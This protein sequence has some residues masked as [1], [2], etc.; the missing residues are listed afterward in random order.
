MALS[1]AADWRNS[2]GAARMSPSCASPDDVPPCSARAPC[3]S[4][5][6]WSAPCHR[7][8][9]LPRRRRPHPR[10]RPRRRRHRHR[11]RHPRRRRRRPRRPTPTPTPQAVCPYNGR[12]STIQRPG[13]TR[14]AC[15]VQVENHPSA[16]APGLNSADMVVEAPVEGDTTRFSA[17]FLCG[18]VAGSIG[19]VRTTATTTSTTGSRC[20]VMTFNFGGAG[21]CSTSCRQRHALRERH[22]RPVA[23]LRA[24]QRAGCAAQRVLRPRRRRAS[25]RGARGLAS[26]SRA[27]DRARRSCSPPTPT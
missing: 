13:G 10:R 26:P 11:R 4:P 19:P 12:R 15:L 27:G 2:A 6:S 25:D 7:P 16:A 22:H 17:I 8:Q 21:R 5:P 1:L 24:R 23:V 14:A 18:E 9:R 20:G 3:S